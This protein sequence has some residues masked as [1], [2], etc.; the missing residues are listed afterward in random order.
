VQINT[1]FDI[2]DDLFHVVESKEPVTVPCDAC[3]D[4]LIRLLDGKQYG[5]PKCKGQGKLVQPGR[6][7]LEI[8]KMRVREVAIR[9]VNRWGA[10]KWDAQPE[11]AKIHYSF[12]C[13]SQRTNQM[14]EADIVKAFSAEKLPGKLFR[15]R[16]AA[17]AAINKHDL[18]RL[19]S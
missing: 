19:V 16:E 15:S 6:L 12:W 18:T 13:E 11:P 4:G 14:G 7:V 3:K 1:M 8:K 2:G 10:K 5:C 9:R 17:Q